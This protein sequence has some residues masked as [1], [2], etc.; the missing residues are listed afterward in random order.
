[1]AIRL[2]VI[3]R[4]IRYH[5]RDLDL[6][7]PDHPTFVVDNVISSM[8]Q[9]VIGSIGHSATW[10]TMKALVAGTNDYDVA[11]TAAEIHTAA[12]FKLETTGTLV[13]KVSPEFLERAR[14]GVTA[15]RGVPKILTLI[16]E[17]AAAGTNRS[18]NLIVYPTPSVSEN[19]LW[20][21]SDLPAP[22]SADADG[23]PL[24]H[25]AARALE[26]MCAGELLA[27]SKEPRI[28][29]DVIALWN[30]RASDALYDEEVRTR[31]LRRGRQMNASTGP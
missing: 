25:L 9:T 31:Q 28:S 20:L 17:S 23:V 26:L 8:M 22:V 21:H 11:A 16:E 5:L 13:E 18:L 6:Q 14:E 1:M 4:N 10:G 27:A 19:L 2:D 3:R 24:S 30:K 12:L 15:V 7:S 29:K